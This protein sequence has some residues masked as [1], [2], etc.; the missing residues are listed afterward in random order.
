MCHATKRREKR[1]ELCSENLKNSDHLENLGTDGKITLKYVLRAQ[2]DSVWTGF[3]WL[4]IG[5]GGGP[6]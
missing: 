3:I 1:T 5:T 6:L 2:G 4:R